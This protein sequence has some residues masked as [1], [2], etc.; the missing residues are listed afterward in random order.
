MKYYFIYVISY[1][2]LSIISIYINKIF[3]LPPGVSPN[4]FV[5]V[6]CVA[7]FI[8]KISNIEKL[9]N[10]KKLI[11]PLL[12]SSTAIVFLYSMMVLFPEWREGRKEITPFVFLTV[13]LFNYLVGLVTTFYVSRAKK[14]SNNSVR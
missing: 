14:N 11:L 13:F 2:L 1:F 10:T 9:T 7:F 6:G 4:I 12:F 8:N 3:D 5:Q